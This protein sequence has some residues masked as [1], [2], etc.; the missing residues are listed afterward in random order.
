MRRN[1]RTPKIKTEKGGRK[2]GREGRH[3]VI[4]FSIPRE[5]VTLL[6]LPPALTRKIT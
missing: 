5:I 3:R 1:I 2:K 6:N 4:Y